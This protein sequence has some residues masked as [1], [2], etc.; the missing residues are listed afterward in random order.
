MYLSLSRKG[1]WPLRQQVILWPTFDVE[2]NIDNPQKSRWKLSFRITSAISLRSLWH[3]RA[4]D[5]LQTRT[6]AIRVG[7]SGRNCGGGGGLGVAVNRKAYAGMR[8]PPGSLIWDSWC[9]KGYL[10]RAVFL[11]GVKYCKPFKASEIWAAIWTYLEWQIMLFNSLWLA[12]CCI[13]RLP[14]G[15]KWSQLERGITLTKCKVFLDS[16]DDGFQS[17][18]RNVSKRHHNSFS[19]DCSHPN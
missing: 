14:R 2:Y 3:N 16:S 18:C 8:R 11:R 4:E 6:W 10:Y 5:W 15:R 12:I 7:V 1:S 9:R 19:Q 17:G 13:L